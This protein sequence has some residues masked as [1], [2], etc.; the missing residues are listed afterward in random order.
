M[1]NLDWLLNQKS[2]INCYKLGNQIYKVDTPIAFQV[3]SPICASHADDRSLQVFPIQPYMHRRPSR[4]KHNPH[5]RHS[6]YSLTQITNTLYASCLRTISS[7]PEN[8]PF[9]ML[10]TSSG[11]ELVVSTEKQTISLNITVAEVNIFGG[12]ARPNFNS[13]ATYLHFE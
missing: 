10:T 3:Q 2:S 4:P 12:T 1:A 6:L 8:T 13:L 9:N 11:V 5:T 7:N